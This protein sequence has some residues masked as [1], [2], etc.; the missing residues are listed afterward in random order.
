MEYASKEVLED[1]KE[2]D[3]ATL[4]NAVI[5]SMGATQGG[6]ELEDKGG[7]PQNYTGPGIRCLLPELGRA[8]GYAITAE[9]TTNDP[10]S[11][12]IPWDEYYDL[13]EQ[14]PVPMV[15]VMKDV[16]SRS[17]RGASFGSAL[18]RRGGG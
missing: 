5:E 9:V 7:M 6:K 4:F 18:P 2:F 1:L 11:E 10:D 14:T 12:A 3:T 8:V 13:M 17:G 15:A 16:D